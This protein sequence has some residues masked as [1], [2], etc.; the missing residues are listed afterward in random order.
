[1]FFLQKKLWFYFNNFAIRSN[2][3]CAIFLPLKLQHAL[4][5]DFYA[6][7]K[8]LLALK[9]LLLIYTGVISDY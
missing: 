4:V 8:S 1:V 2:H 6:S 5:G 9:L 7:N 3:E